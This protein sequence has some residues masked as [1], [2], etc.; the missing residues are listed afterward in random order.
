M[1]APR[2]SLQRLLLITTGCGLIF[3]VV[4]QGVRGKTVAQVLTVWMLCGLAL[5]VMYALTFLTAWL[6]EL[7]VPLPPDTTADTPFAE[8]KLPPRMV[9]PENE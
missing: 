4:A 5:V 2:Y 9:P 8:H 7:L 3:F 1:F 6:V